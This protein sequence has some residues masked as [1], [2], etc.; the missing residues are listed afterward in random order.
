MI[1]FNQTPP[2]TDVFGALRLALMSVF[3]GVEVI[4][5][6]SNQVSQPKGDYISMLPLMITRLSTNSSEYPVAANNEI[7]RQENLD[8]DYQ[9]QLDFYGK[10][11]SNMAAIVFNLWRSD[12]LFQYGIKPMFTSD[13][14]QF[15]FIGA[16]QQMVERW[17]MDV[18]LCYSPIVILSQQSANQLLANLIGVP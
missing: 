4:K 17:N 5:G 8:T 2:Q 6:Q 7:N 1:L 11:S 16:S 13:P 3:S 12:Y 18:H 15:S 10:E 9:V 14:R